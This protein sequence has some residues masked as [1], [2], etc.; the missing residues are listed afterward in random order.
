MAKSSKSIVAWTDVHDG[1]TTALCSAEPYNSELD[2]VIKLNRTQKTLRNAWFDSIDDLV[3][4][5]DLVV[6]NGEPIDGANKKQVGQQTWSTNLEDQMNDFIRLT[7]EIPHKDIMFVRG[8]GYH[9]T[10]DATNFEEVLAN[11]LNA[12]K[13]RA[14]GGHGATDDFAFIEMYGK[15]FNFAH[16]IGFNKS[17][18]YRTTALAREMAGMHF[19]H[20]KLGRA[21]FIIRSHVHY[22][23]HIEFV[24][25]HGI[26]TPAWKYP[27]HHLFRGGLAGTTP[28]VGLVEIIIEPNG[29]TVVLPH[30][31]KID[32]KAQVRHL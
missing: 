5:P 28:D 21:D 20:D 22:F 18:A 2:T 29:E 30:I 32:M 7:K 25:T 17:P 1:A 11:R 27:D 14:Y 26:L 12:V 10:L 9:T 16:H 31:A 15:I 24:N 23:V 3:Q 6:V 13:Y 8:S 19:E 4:K